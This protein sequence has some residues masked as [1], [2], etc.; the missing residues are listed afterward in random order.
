MRIGSGLVIA[1]ACVV[2]LV[3]TALAAGSASAAYPVEVRSEADGTPCNPCEI[4]IEGESQAYVE[5]PLI[6]VSTCEDTFEAE[7]YADGS[8]HVTTHTGTGHPGFGGQ[9]LV[10]KC[11]GVGEPA[12]ETEW[13][14]QV[15]EVGNDI[16]LE[17]RFCLDASLNVNGTGGHC[18]LEANIEA[19]IGGEHHY[20]IDAPHRHCTGVNRV[21]DAT[22]EIHDSSTLSGN[23]D[24]IE[25]GP[26]SFEV[27]EEDGGDPCNPCNV[28]MEGETQILIEDTGVPIFICEDRLEAEI[29]ADGSGHVTSVVKNSHSG[30]P[31]LASNCAGGES[32]WPFQLETG[33]ARYHMRWCLGSAHCDISGDFSPESSGS[34]HYVVDAEQ[35]HCAG[36]NR[37]FDGSW[38][39]QEGEATGDHD[40]IEIAYGEAAAA[41]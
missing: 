23:H 3:A 10:A 37:I 4:L 40:A 15:E 12:A 26:R 35:Q 41:G 8:G 1:L 31:C 39:I 30:I 14:F 7:I 24:A 29:W 17:M 21:L 2:A 5:N 25:I 20:I 22:W 18:D 13:P 19:E 16:A 34:H 38:E 33:G 11:N 36:L 32:Q 9:C 6:L 27:V 28:L